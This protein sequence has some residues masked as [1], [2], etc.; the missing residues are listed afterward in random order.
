MNLVSLC[1][2][3][4]EEEQ[5]EEETVLTFEAAELPPWGI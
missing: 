1:Y 5:E 4:K 2:Q 3:G